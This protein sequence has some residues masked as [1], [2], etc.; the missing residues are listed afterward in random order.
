MMSDDQCTTFSISNETNAYNNYV[1]PIYN[2]S[3]LQRSKVDEMKLISAAN[4]AAIRVISERSVKCCWP[5]MENRGCWKL[6]TAVLI[7]AV[8]F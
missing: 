4:S 3:Q 2:Y 1:R 6:Q 7:S 5:C 8:L